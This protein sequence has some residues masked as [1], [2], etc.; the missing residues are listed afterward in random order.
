M[1]GR[2]RQI[3]TR[4]VVN[5]DNTLYPVSVRPNETG[6]YIRHE[7][8]RISVFSNWVIGNRLFRGVVND[9]TVS[10]KIDF[11]TGGFILTHAGSSIMA[12]IR[13]PRV[14]ELEKF[15]PPKTRSASSG[16]IIAS[17]LA[18]LITTIKVAVGDL[19]QNGQELCVIEAMKMENII[20][21]DFNGKIKNIAIQEGDQVNCGQNMF[22]FEVE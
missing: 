14:A 6:F 18:G 4:W 16:N 10:V 20:W 22:E 8:A 7:K 11:V 2:K 17:P 19:I 12:T 15:M 5:I 9:K 3:G 21:A 1:P 13:S